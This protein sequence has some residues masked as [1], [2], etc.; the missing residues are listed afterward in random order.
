MPGAM[1]ATVPELAASSRSSSTTN[2]HRPVRLAGQRPASRTGRSIC[3][4]RAYRSIASSYPTGRRHQLTTCASR[5]RCRAQLDPHL[6]EL[7]QREAF[8]NSRPLSAA[9]LDRGDADYLGWQYQ[10]KDRTFK[11]SQTIN[12][13]DAAH[14]QRDP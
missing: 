9:F 11:K 14:E 7:I 3:R 5:H 12:H 10:A 4:R 1:T 13:L 2:V 8:T 6:A